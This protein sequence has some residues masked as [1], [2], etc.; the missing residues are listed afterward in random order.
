MKRNI[1]WII[2]IAV[3]IAIFWYFCESQKKQLQEENELAIAEAVAEALENARSRGVAKEPPVRTKIVYVEKEA[4]KEKKKA[5]GKVD[6][7]FTDERD[8]NQYKFIEI[9]EQLWMAQNLDFESSDSWCYEGDAQNCDNWGRMYTWEAAAN[10]CPD[11]WR[12]PAD[13][14]WDK[15]IW[16]FGGNEVAG[17]HLKAGGESDFEVLM[18]GYRDKKGFY[19]KADTSAYFWSATEQEDLRYASFRG[20]YKKYSNVGPYTYTKTDGFSVRCVKDK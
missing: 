9:E 5:A 1:V 11:G 10:A 3:L 14:D 4:P 6:N 12:L 17:R 13:E 8:G 19:G 16:R 2:I 15:L 20:F 18:A 7:M